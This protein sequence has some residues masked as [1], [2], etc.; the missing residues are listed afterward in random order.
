MIRYWIRE[1]RG[2]RTCFHHDHVSGK[3]WI[4]GR[5]FNA[6]ANKAHRCTRCG[7][8]WTV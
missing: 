7:K 3:S 6:G 5:L 2:R 1:W 8:T 4:E